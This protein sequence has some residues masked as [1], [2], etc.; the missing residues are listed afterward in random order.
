M[1]KLLLLFCFIYSVSVYAQYTTPN[2]GVNW[3]LADLVTNSGGVVTGTF[4]NYLIINKINVSASDRIYILPGSVVTFTGSTSGFD[5]SG[6]FFAVGTSTDSIIFTSTSNDSTGNAYNGFYFLDAS[7]DTACII[8]YA[9]IEYAY[10]GFRCLGASP[11]LSHSYLWKNRRGANLSSDSHPVISNNK[12]ERSYEYGITMTLGCSPLIENNI[13]A[14][15][16]TENTSAKNQISIGL[17]GNNSPIIRNNIIYGGTSIVTGGISVWVSGASAF[18]NAVIEGNEIYNNSFGMTL[19]SSSNGIINAQVRNNKIYNNKLNPNAQVSGSG[20]NVN[21]SP[22]NTPV[23]TGNEIFNNWWGITIQ[24]GTTVQAGPQPNIGNLEN[25]DT[26]DDGQNILYDNIQ[27]TTVYD[28][29]NNCTNDI[30][31]QNNDWRVYDSLSIEQHVFHKADN[32]LHGTVKFIPFSQFLP[33]ELVSFSATVNNNSV[34]LKWQTASEIN[35]RGFGIERRQTSDVKSQ[36]SWE[37]IGFITGK[38]S[39]SEINNYSFTDN[40][41]VAGKY[42][43]WLKQFDLDGS[44]TYSNVVE[45]DINPVTDFVLYQN[46]PNPFNPS[47]K[48]KFILPNVETHRDASLLKT[49]KVY[50]VLG[51]EVATLV[52]DNMNAGSYEIDFDASSLSAGVY[53]YRL[54]AGSFIQTNK[55]L[56][57]K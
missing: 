3:N 55:M 25:A 19:L 51:N 48:I 24:N 43:Y 20:I 15:N 8:S 14:F 41:V 46:Y 16:N 6:K 7:V 10:Y 54:T 27:G 18:S 30:M 12:I 49:L 29:Y 50:D 45:V 26:T 11:T 2:T 13:I 44:F 39:T 33:V 28:L 56:L 42:S 4:P 17:Q 53:F 32:S 21:G 9:R 1:K 40:S 23:I 57:L 37:S 22:F 36:M 47:T 34:I 31:A 52:N 5:V 38:G 35:N